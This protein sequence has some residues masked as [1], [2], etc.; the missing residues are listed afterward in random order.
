VT[1]DVTPSSPA[2][3]AATRARVDAVRRAVFTLACGVLLVAG[4]VLGLDMWSFVVLEL[5]L[6]AALVAADRFPSARSARRVTDDPVEAAFAALA[7]DGWH[8]VDRVALP[9]GTVDHVFIG[10]G[11]VFAVVA[12]DASDELTR[13]RVRRQAAALESLLHH[14]VVALRVVDVTALAAALRSRP[15]IVSVAGVAELHARLR[16]QL[17]AAP[18]LAERAR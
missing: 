3:D 11:G 17:D 14:P 7:A 15:T 8:R 9:H 5:G 13:R 18:G 4:V 16:A 1:P 2:A 12:T 6:V 10:P